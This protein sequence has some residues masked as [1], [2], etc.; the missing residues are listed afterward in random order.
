MPL[1]GRGIR[2]APP[3]SSAPSLALL[4]GLWRSL[5]GWR[6]LLSLWACCCAH[7]ASSGLLRSPPGLAI[8]SDTVSVTQVLCPQ[9][10]NTCPRTAY[11]LPLCIRLC[12]I[13][14]KISRYC[15][16]GDI[17]SC[18]YAQNSVVMHQL[19]I[20]QGKPYPPTGYIG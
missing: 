2:S 13:S 20:L 3:P 10:K 1:S 7:W 18:I 15:Y 19:C 5:A 9:T 4:L 14:V 11:T 16:K 8:Y 12:I 6:G 17:L